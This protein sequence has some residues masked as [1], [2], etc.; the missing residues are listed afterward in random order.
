MTNFF[1]NK[2]L[3]ID[4]ILISTGIDIRLTENRDN[5]FTKEFERIQEQFLDDYQTYWD[6]LIYTHYFI[7]QFK[8]IKEH[9]AKD[10]KDYLNKLSIDNVNL[11]G[12][13]FEILTYARLI[14]HNIDFSK[15]KLN[16]DFEIKLNN[17][18]I[19]IEC[20]TRQ[21]DKDGFYLES[22]TD[23]ILKKEA[24]GKKQGYS[25]HNTAL[26]IEVTKTFFNSLNKENPLSNE[27]LIDILNKT[28][29]QVSFGAV[30][31]ITTFYS[32]EN[33]IVYGNPLVQYNK[34]FNE[35]IPKLYERIFNL[36]SLEATPIFKPR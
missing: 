10:F 8:K 19:F 7:S 12:E 29:T 5:Y 20:G 3:L 27:V 16:P 24:Q 33:G 22:L 6:H 2:E 9:K 36:K 34:N 35:N 11:R 18:T 32:K 23:A 26:H 1:K 15:P 25:N 21:T 4:L 28:I 13:K 14:D 31:F 30:V 17:D